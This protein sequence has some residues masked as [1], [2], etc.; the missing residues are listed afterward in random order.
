MDYLCRMP[1]EEITRRS[2]AMPERA[3]DKVS[4]ALGSGNTIAY[5]VPLKNYLAMIKA[6]D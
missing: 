6:I 3:A 4:Y 1:E 2:R 5:Y